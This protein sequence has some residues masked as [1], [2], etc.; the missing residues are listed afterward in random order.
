MRINQDTSSGEGGVQMVI[1]LNK[2]DKPGIDPEEIKRQ[3]LA[4][5]VELE[6]A[7]GDVPVVPVSG[8]TGE[9]LDDLEETLA[10][11]AELAD[12]RAERTG[13]P[14]GVVIES[15]IE[16]GRGHVATM[17]VKRG[18]LKPGSFVGWYLLV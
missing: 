7:G 8:K 15:R 12:L 10:A 3:L 4:L 18:Q 1:A 11:M 9:G 14:E 2:I 6:E 17:L 13:L 5:G 16:K